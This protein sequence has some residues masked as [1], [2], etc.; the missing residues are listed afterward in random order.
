MKH[1][2]V[3]WLRA[4]SLRFWQGIFLHPND[5]DNYRKRH[6]RIEQELATYLTELARNRG[7]TAHKAI[8]VLLASDPNVPRSMI[9]IDNNTNSQISPN[10]STVDMDTIVL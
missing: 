2:C 9:R 8:T 7:F 10:D 4:T 5:F 3:A 6:F 1:F